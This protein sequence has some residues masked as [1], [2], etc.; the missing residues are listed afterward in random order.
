MRE[1]EPTFLSA[2]WTPASRTF[3]QEKMYLRFSKGRGFA[4]NL[5]NPRI[6]WLFTQFLANQG[7][8]T[9]WTAYHAPGMTAIL[10]PS[11][12]LCH[13]AL[14]GICWFLLKHGFSTPKVVARFNALTDIC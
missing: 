4:R 1:V 6:V 11:T 5:T 13:K 7:D 9:F 12:S 2:A 10:V 8:L 3:F 14:A